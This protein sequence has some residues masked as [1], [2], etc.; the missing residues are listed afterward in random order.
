[1]IKHTRNATTENAA[2]LSRRVRRMRIQVNLRRIETLVTSLGFQ[3]AT[4]ITASELGGMTSRSF[5]TR[6]H[7]SFAH[8]LAQQ[9]S[10]LHYT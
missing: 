9:S 2:L 3:L 6:N 5:T 4:V 7:D 10:A 8:R 1:M